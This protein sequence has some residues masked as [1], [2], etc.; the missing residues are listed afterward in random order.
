MPGT[1]IRAQGTRKEDPDL[2]VGKI[3]FSHCDGLKLC[4]EL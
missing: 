4:F 2:V 1:V 3:R